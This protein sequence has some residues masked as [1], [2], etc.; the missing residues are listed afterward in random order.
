MRASTL[1]ADDD[2][3]DRS[4]GYFMLIY[5]AGSHLTPRLLY[6]NICGFL[7][8]GLDILYS[9]CIDIWC[10]VVMEG[11]GSPGGNIE[12]RLLWLSLLPLYI[13]NLTGYD[14]RN[15]Y[16]HYSCVSSRTGFDLRPPALRSVPIS[17][18]SLS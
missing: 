17:G 11:Y 7:S 5:R 12:G 18:V 2:P 13:S 6:L 3:G 16:R 9:T 1:G 4:G 14:D 8:V 15:S 10:L